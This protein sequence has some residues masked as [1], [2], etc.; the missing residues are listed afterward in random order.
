[1]KKSE[2]TR[3]VETVFL[4]LEKKFKFKKTASDFHANGVTITFQ[5][6]TTEVCLNYEIGDYPWLTIGNISN[7]KEDRASLDWLLVELGEL[8]APTTDAAFFPP[9]MEDDQLEPEL[10]KKS[11]QLILFA[12]DMLNGDFSVLPKLKTRADNY[13]AECK[14][15]ADRYKA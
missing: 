8:E 7:P 4:P 2:F 10:R 6:A 15:I 9:E 13:L 5:N 12:E 1:M 3:L 14:K 11:E